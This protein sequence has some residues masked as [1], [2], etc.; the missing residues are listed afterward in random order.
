MIYNSVNV[1][2]ILLMEINENYACITSSWYPEKESIN[3]FLI[4]FNFLHTEFI[5]L[6]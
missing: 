1:N 5:V 2:F 4:K 6:T 3:K